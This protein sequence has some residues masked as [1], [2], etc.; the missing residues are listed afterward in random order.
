MLF[1]QDEL[2]ELEKDLEGLDRF[3]FGEAPLRLVSRRQNGG[4]GGLERRELHEKIKEKLAEYG[5]LSVTEDKARSSDILDESLFRM[6]KIQAMRRPTKRNQQSVRNFIYNTG[7]QAI[8]ESAWIRIGPD[9]AAVAH[10]PE[11]EWLIGFLEDIL[12]K[13]SRKAAI[14]SRSPLS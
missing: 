9:L 1:L 7:C 8:E 3:E 10:D 14:V 6:Q 2:V 13:I 4:R 12:L 5:E 11:H